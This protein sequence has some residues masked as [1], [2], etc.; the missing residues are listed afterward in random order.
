[1]DKTIRE[2]AS[3]R[4]GGLTA[5]I[6]DKK[7]TT[8]EEAK[9]ADRTAATATTTAVANTAGK[10]TA[11]ATTSAVETMAVTTAAVT[12]AEAKMAD[13]TTD[14]AMVTTTMV[15]EDSE[16]A[17][18]E[19]TVAAIAHKS[20]VV[21]S[22]ADRGQILKPEPETDSATHHLTIRKTATMENWTCK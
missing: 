6:G 18:A 13:R 10:M 17:K 1:M 9:V 12:M 4:T 20:A 19:V 7:T 5:K 14:T 8:M 2:T 15:A 11:T 22:A 3:D 16:A 21:D